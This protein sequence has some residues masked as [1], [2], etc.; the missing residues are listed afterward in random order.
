MTFLG[1]PYI[2]HKGNNRRFDLCYLQTPDINFNGTFPFE[3]NEH[4]CIIYKNEYH[5]GSAS[6]ACIYDIHYNMG[7]MDEACILK[8]ISE[9]CDGKELKKAFDKLFGKYMIML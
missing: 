7:G 6:Y 9:E 5:K 1:F 4:R 8:R 2:I 3:L